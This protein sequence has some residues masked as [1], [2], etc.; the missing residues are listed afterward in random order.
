MNILNFLF[1]LC[2]ST[3]FLTK[4]SDN[5]TFTF[6]IV[7]QNNWLDI[8]RS[9][10]QSMSPSNFTIIPY[11]Y[12]SNSN[13][14][15][16]NQGSVL[17]IRKKLNNQ[18]SDEKDNLDK[19]SASSGSSASCN[20]KPE[21]SNDIEDTDV[22]SNSAPLLLSSVYSPSF[23]DSTYSMENDLQEEQKTGG[24]NYEQARIGNI[25]DNFMP[26]K[27]SDILVEVSDEDRRYELTGNEPCE[28][29]VYLG[30]ILHNTNVEVI[31]YELSAKKILCVQLEAVHGNGYIWAMLGVHKTMPNIEPS[32]FPTKKVTKSFFS[33]D[34]SVTQPKAI[35]KPQMNNDG[36]S[37][38]NSDDQ[39]QTQQDNNSKPRAY[40]HIGGLVG[41]LGMVQSKVKAHVEGTFYVVFAYYRPFDPTRNANTKILHLNVA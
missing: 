21:N 22:N 5:R 18:E 19:S 36:T 9:I 29:T 15:K 17:L 32:H 35:E 8:A 37:G 31:N 20:S 26:Q 24:E 23:I 2:S 7:N 40:K 39:L 25:P 41:G 30:D 1:I 3:A 33:R 34:I 12:I 4:C 16:E 27:I 6:D 10:F 13:N 14:T 11:S 38:T 28:A